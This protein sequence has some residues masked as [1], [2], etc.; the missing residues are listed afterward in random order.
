[1]N[2]LNALTD[3]ILAKA[4]NEAEEIL[5]EATAES[6][7]ITSEARQKATESRG[8]IVENFQHKAEDLEKR[9]MIEVEL[10]GKKKKL[11]VKHRLIERS[12][13]EA[14]TALQ[15]LPAEKRIR[16]LA[17]LLAAAGMAKG[18]VV[19][20]SGSTAEWSSIVKVAN[21]I[22]SRSGNTSLVSLSQEQPDFTGGFL[23]KGTGFTINS[24]YQAILDEVKESLVP[25]IATVLFGK[26]EG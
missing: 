14:L 13:S 20:G 15:N 6:D 25:Q 19:L 1:M 8:K 9:I 12:F 2:D 11:A 4:R 10:E 5:K 17:E 21:E 16:F 7:R 18:G 23:L 22:I 26:E 3:S 24:S